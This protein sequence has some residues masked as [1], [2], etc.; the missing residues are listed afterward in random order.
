MI[1][2]YSLRGNL[3]FIKDN[4]LVIDCSGVGYKCTCSLFTQAFFSEKLNQEINVYTYLMVRQD[5]LELFGFSDEEELECFKLLTSV[6]GVG[7]KAALG[8]LSQFSSTK[9][10]QI[11]SAGDNK[12][13]TTAPGIGP[14]TAKRIIL[15][16]KE[17]FLNF[18]KS[19]VIVENE[20]QKN[21]ENKNEAL[22]ALCSLGYS[23]AEVMPWIL[24]LSES[25]SV[26]EIIRST[27]KHMSKGV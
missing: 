3:I 14:K 17:K 21:S 8:I 18:K 22:K 12:S 15:E 7:S 27:L 19:N 26:E 5:A 2:I 23:Q 20:L 1:L 13:L 4:F 24:N 9:I 6:S 25:L 16:L 10:A 11:I